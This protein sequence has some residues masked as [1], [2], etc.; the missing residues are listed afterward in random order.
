MQIRL[1]RTIKRVT[2]GLE[3]NSKKEGYR[4][5][6][7]NVSPFCMGVFEKK[8]MFNLRIKTEGE[9]GGNEVPVSGA[10]YFQH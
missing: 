7:F 4:K 1:K 10:M 6:M 9:N 8:H 3:D 2:V 5:K